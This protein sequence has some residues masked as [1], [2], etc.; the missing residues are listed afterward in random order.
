MNECSFSVN[1]MREESFDGWQVVPAPGIQ[2][3]GLRSAS[4]TTDA[5]WAVTTLLMPP[6]ASWRRAR[7]TSLR[8]PLFRS[9]RPGSETD[10]IEAISRGYRPRTIDLRF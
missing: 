4:D 3:D 10:R 2:R 7:T 9:I 1:R 6:P 8:R 5:E